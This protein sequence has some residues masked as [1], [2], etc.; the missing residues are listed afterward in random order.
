MCV[1][2]ATRAGEGSSLEDTAFA[3]EGAWWD[4]R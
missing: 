3:R 2:G 1:R 4:G